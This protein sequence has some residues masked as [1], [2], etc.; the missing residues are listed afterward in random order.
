V[1]H[2]SVAAS[3]FFKFQCLTAGGIVAGW[4]AMDLSIS[5]LSDSVAETA[6]PIL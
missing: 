1:N 4:I 5:S 3:F 6:V 2:H